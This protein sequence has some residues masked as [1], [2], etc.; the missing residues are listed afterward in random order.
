MIQRRYWAC[1]CH[2]APRYNPR[3]SLPTVGIHP[4]RSLRGG[5]ALG[6]DAGENAY[7]SILDAFKHLPAQPGSGPGCLSPV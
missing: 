1:V 6:S 5:W 7:P 3:L 4:A 2:L